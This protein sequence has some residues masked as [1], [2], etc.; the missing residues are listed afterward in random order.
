M[1][2]VLRAMQVADLVEDDVVDADR[3]HG[4]ASDVLDNCIAAMQHYSM[5]KVVPI[6]R[7]GT[8]TL[9]P[10]FRKKMGIDRIDNALML[11]REEKGM[12]IMELAAAV[13]VRDLP[14]S[15]VRGWI[16]E[17]E[18]DGKAIRKIRRSSK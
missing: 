5:V 17:D 18:A 4:V 9:P 3:G 16:A 1:Q 13:P 15:T 14:E 12:L 2:V 6:S 10:S 11:V 8:I 7:R